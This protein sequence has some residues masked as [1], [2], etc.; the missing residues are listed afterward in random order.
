MSWD[1]RTDEQTAEDV[2]SYPVIDEEVSRTGRTLS[3]IGFVCA[4][5]SLLWLPVLFGAAAV[6]CG[7]VGWRSGDRL[8]MWAA[9]AGVV[10]A[11]AGLAIAAA[12]VNNAKIGY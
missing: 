7:L 6:V 8:G 9:V 1:L 5:I 4:V 3:V 11:A 2:R 12:T 10:A